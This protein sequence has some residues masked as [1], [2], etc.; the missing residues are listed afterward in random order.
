MRSLVFLLAILPATVIS[1]TCTVCEFALLPPHST[2]C[3]DTCE[4]DVCFIVVNKY[5]NGTINA[6][7]MHLHDDEMFE[8]KAVCQRGANDNRCACS[9]TDHCNDPKVKLASYVFTESP[10]LENYQWLPQIQPPMPS[11]QPILPP[12]DLPLPVEGENDMNE[13]AAELE[14]GVESD[15]AHELNTTSVLSNEENDDL[16]TVK[17]TVGL[18]VRDQTIRLNNEPNLETTSTRSFTSGQGSVEVT[19]VTQEASRSQ[20]VTTDGEKGPNGSGAVRVLL[21]VVLPMILQHLL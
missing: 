15:L 18:N 9:T 21:A 12:E 7:C 4:G 10:V 5:F 11:L 1:L 3:N 13:T 6:G 8:N 17:T 2:N 14:N 19:K 16:L 20:N